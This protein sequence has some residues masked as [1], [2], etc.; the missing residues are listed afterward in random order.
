MQLGITLEKAQEINP[1]LRAD[2]ADP[3][4][5]RL[6]DMATR[7]GDSRARF[8]TRGGHRHIQWTG[9]RLRAAAAQRRHSYHPVPVDQSRSWAYSRW[10]SWDCVRSPS[11]RARPIWCARAGELRDIRTSTS[12]ILRST[13]SYPRA[14]PTGIS[15]RE[16]RYARVHARARPDRFE[17]IIAGISLYRPGPM[18]FIPRYLEGKEIRIHAPTTTPSW[19]PR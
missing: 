10:I 13:G 11:I 17:D 16:R 9:Y 7:L 6:V 8:H 5:K 18:D 3:Q 1:Q 12:A 14:I 15:A 2:G 19:R 4:V